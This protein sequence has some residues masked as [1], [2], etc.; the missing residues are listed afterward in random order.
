ML[1][2]IPRGKIYFSLPVIMK[3]MQLFLTGKVFR[4][5]AIKHFEHELAQYLGC[6]EVI[7]TSSGTLS[8][9]LCLKALDC[10]EGDEIIIPAY[11]VPEVIGMIISLGMKPIFVDICEGTYNINP[12]LIEREIT[13][14][15]KVL[16]LTHIYG[17]P[18]D[19]DPI[20]ALAQKFNLKVIEDGAQALGAEYKGKKIGTYGLVAYF[21][22]GLMKNLNTLCGGAIATDDREVGQRIRNEISSYKF[23][24][25]TTILRRFFV[26]WGITFFSHPII[27]SLITYPCIRASM[28]INE[29]FLHNFLRGQK[30]SLN[31][32]ISMMDHY[33]K[34]FTNLQAAIGIL[35]LRDI[36]YYSE[37]RMKNAEVL[38]EYL[39]GSQYLLPRTLAYVKNIFL[40]YVIQAKQN[41]KLLI[42]ALLKKGIDVTEGYV[43]N[44][45]GMDEFKTYKADCPV[46][47]AL[48]RDNIYIPIH[49][50]LSGKHMRHIA[51]TL[52]E[53]AERSA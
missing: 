9:Y 50:P 39:N 40:N 37:I 3:S 7:T 45:A 41:K 2:K 17:Q 25:F 53:L 18:C 11:T 35:Q 12:H 23:P 52:R 13:K 49:A 36:D 16:L 26:A 20:I 28:I 14:K 42:K 5:S 47:A 15:T 32:S 51:T 19:I 34:A 43:R 21:S 24:S 6:K 48:E 27:F 33:K 22:F 1:R 38:N 30:A 46:S 4:G 10:K 29:T 31:Q 8:L 44:C